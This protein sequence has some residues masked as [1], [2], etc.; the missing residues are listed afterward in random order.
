MALARTPNKYVG[1]G[2]EVTPGT[3]G[4]IDHFLRVVDANLSFDK[5]PFKSES[6][7]PDW[8]KAIY[9]RA[10]HS[11]GPVVTEE[12]YTGT[13]LFWHSLFGT[14]TFS[15]NTPSAGAHTH[16]FT[17]APT[18]NNHPAISIEQIEGMG[19]A[20]ERCH[21]GM[22]VQKGTVEFAPGQILRTTFDFVGMGY[23][24]G[25]A[26]SPTFATR[27][28]VLPSHKTALSLGGN[29]V[30][31]LSG[32]VS[33]SI[34][35]ADDREHYGDAVFKAPEVRGRPEAMFTL[36]SEWNDATGADFEQFLQD[37]ENGAEVN[38][39]ILQ[40]SGPVI[41]ATAVNRAWA[42]VA[43]KAFI[44]VTKK[45]GSGEQ[46][47]KCTVEGE[48]TTGLALTLINDTSAAVT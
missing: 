8:H 42:M 5:Q 36:E 10:G 14:Y 37:Y 34:P 1:F 3:K 11:L 19:G 23:S 26:T 39:L 28:P 32:S 18:T 41:G 48:I 4:T 45:Q 15:A 46:V 47:T 9:F 29:S 27:Y 22:Y 33:L 30:T 35:R 20:T 2:G 12:C 25:A 31:V 13:E 40:H 6:M 38:G 43:S 44:T 7:D 16:A 21:L 17:F 24:V